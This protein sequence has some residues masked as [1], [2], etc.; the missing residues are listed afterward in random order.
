MTQESYGRA[1]ARVFIVQEAVVLWDGPA[2]NIFVELIGQDHEG[3]R[4]RCYQVDNCQTICGTEH[5]IIVSEHFWLS[6][7][8]LYHVF[9][10]H[11]HLLSEIYP[12]RP[13]FNEH[14]KLYDTT[15]DLGQ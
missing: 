11:P 1:A 10:T 7:F 8:Y 12:P 3:S 13:A 5:C 2:H 4:E 6:F 9:V 14:L 15:I